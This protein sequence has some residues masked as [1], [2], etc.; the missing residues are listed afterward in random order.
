MHS[1]QIERGKKFFKSENATKA[2][3]QPLHPIPTSK[4]VSIW[5]SMIHISTNQWFDIGV[6]WEYVQTTTQPLLPLGSFKY[7]P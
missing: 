4:R 5:T 2:T 1:D 3:I 6:H 7:I